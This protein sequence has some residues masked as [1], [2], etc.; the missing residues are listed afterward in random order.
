MSDNTSHAQDQAAATGRD[1]G[2]RFAAGNAGAPGNPFARRVA[3]LRSA[4]TAFTNGRAREAAGSSTPPRA[5]L[6]AA[7]AFDILAREAE[8]VPGAVEEDELARHAGVGVDGPDLT[9]GLAVGACA[10]G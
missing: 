1:A 3:A 2:G 4:P 8:G 10:G 5:R 6:R 7:I 9:K